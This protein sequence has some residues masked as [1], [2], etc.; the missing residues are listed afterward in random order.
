M[1]YR[2]R[3][4]IAFMLVPRTGSTS[5]RETLIINEF[6][7][8]IV[9]SEAS[10]GFSW[11]ATYRSSLEAFPGLTSYKIFGVYRDPVERFASGLRYAAESLGLKINSPLDC[12]ALIDRLFAW[13]HKANA[14]GV[15][16]EIFKA[17]VEWLDGPNVTPLCYS[18][19]SEK[20]AN[21]LGLNKQLPRMNASMQGSNMS[22]RAVEFARA[23]YAADYRFA[24][25]AVVSA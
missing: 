13:N 16:A 2:K 1:M 20:I 15:L 6:K 11:H 25:I 8:P 14:M 19:A 10:L 21:I 3:D 17:Q 5:L 23:R 12:D 9:F 7:Y 24:D 4:R 18:N 22:A